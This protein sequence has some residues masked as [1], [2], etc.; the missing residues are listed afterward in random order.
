VSV[1][2]RP[3]STAPHL[4]TVRIWMEDLGGGQREWRGRIQDTTTGEVR[5]ARD[6]LAMVA[7]LVEMAEADSGRPPPP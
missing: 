7:A 4:F 3:A 5:Y 6:W 2:E 1:E